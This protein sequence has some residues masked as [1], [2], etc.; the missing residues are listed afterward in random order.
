[1]RVALVADIPDQLV[2]GGVEDGVDGG[3]EFDYAEPCAKVAA[4]FGDGFDCGFADFVAELLD[5]GVAEGLYVS[6]RV[7]AV[8]QFGG[9]GKGFVLCL[10]VFC[11]FHDLLFLQLFRG[12]KQSFLI[13]ELSSLI[14]KMR[15]GEWGGLFLAWVFLVGE[16]CVV[17]SDL[18]INEF[19]GMFV[20][21]KVLNERK[22]RY[23]NR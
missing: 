12:Q 20:F 15:W 13:K 18:L 3:G 23:N 11:N 21:L 7:D 10:C 17:C 2:F 9:G 1:V 16:F 19:N 22:K 14:E 4:G 8:Q 6:G 5:L